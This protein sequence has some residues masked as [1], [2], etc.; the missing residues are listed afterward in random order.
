MTIQKFAEKYKVAVKKDDCNDE[1]VRGTRAS[2]IYDGFQN[3]MFG[4]FVSFETARKFTSIRKKLVEAGFQ[5]KQIACTEGCFKFDP[6]NAKQSRLAIKLVGA[7]TRREAKPP[8]VAQLAAR[9]AFANRRRLPEQ[10]S[11][12]A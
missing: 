5:P 11:V 12:A 7:R 1:V 3:G 9:E 10:A 2:N 8:S 4:L 6:E